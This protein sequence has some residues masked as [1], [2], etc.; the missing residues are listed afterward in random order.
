M[1]FDDIAEVAEGEKQYEP[2]TPKSSKQSTKV[3]P[4]TP[5]PGKQVQSKK[6]I[7]KNRKQVGTKGKQHGKQAKVVSKKNASKRDGMEKKKKAPPTMPSEEEDGFVSLVADFPED[8]YIGQFTRAT[9]FSKMI[10]DNAGW[11]G[12]NRMIDIS[13]IPG[14]EG[15]VIPMEGAEEGCFVTSEKEAELTQQVPFDSL[16]YSKKSIQYERIR[17]QEILEQAFCKYAVLC[18]LQKKQTLCMETVNAD[19][20][21]RHYSTPGLEAICRQKN[22]GDYNKTIIQNFHEAY[23]EKQIGGD[24]YNKRVSA[25]AKQFNLDESTLAKTKVPEYNAYSPQNA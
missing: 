6:A 11:R 15:M 19:A 22:E 23:P 13:S 5:K 7:V 9:R 1:D 4:K 16:R 18:E 8:K 21:L 12:S 25:F 24:A 14:V 20:L 2:Q 10:R 17:G 3:A